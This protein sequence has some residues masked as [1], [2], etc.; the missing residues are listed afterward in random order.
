M[1]TASIIQEGLSQTE[2]DLIDWVDRYA[3]G[4][5]LLYQ[6]RNEHCGLP[7]DTIRFTRVVRD[8]DEEVL[9][10]HDT[11][12]F[13]ALAGDG[14]WAEAARIHQSIKQIETMAGRHVWTEARFSVAG[15]EIPDGRAS[16]LEVERKVQEYL[17]LLGCTQ[18]VPS[19]RPDHSVRAAGDTSYR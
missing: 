11:I 6:H 5:E 14:R 4:P 12:E 8:A 2:Q 10:R 3:G 1:A 18:V 19:V 7:G 15:P 13:L 9:E 16:H 17:D